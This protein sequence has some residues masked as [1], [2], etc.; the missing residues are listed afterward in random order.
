M[1]LDPSRLDRAFALVAGQVAE[2]R[3]HASALGV[4]TAARTLRVEAFGAEGIKV[5][6]ESLFLLASITKPIVA[7]AVMQLVEEGRLVLSEPLQRYLPAFS[8]EPAEPG[9]PGAEVVTT[10]HILTHSSGLEDVPLEQLAMEQP[11]RQELLRRAC[12][13]R[14]RFVPGTRYEY[15]SNS[16]YLL[17][18][19][20]EQLGRRPFADQLRERLFEPLGMVDTRFDASGAGARTAP[21]RGIG[22]EGERLAMGLHYLAA[23]EL[24]GGGLWGTAEDLLRFGRAMLR[25][26]ELD[27]ARVLAPSSVALMTRLHT[28]DLLEPG[29]PPRRPNYGLGWALPGLGGGLPASGRSFGHSGAT[30]T[31]LLV[32]PEHDLVVVFLRNEWDADPFLSDA[33]I[34]AVYGAVLPPG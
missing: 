15:G 32:D 34:Q 9:L 1:P 21:V 7:T 8:P 5:E 23:L 24:P 13:G 26:G 19:L 27:G 2:G 28:A 29:T 3:S 30:G 31:M 22:L 33:V 11:D 14:L 18:E 6:P 25:G 20:I 4:A 17:A 10:W 16:F 12:T